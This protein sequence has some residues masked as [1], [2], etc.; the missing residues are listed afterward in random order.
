MCPYFVN[1]PRTFQPRKT[2]LFSGLNIW[3]QDIITTTYNNVET[4]QYV[5]K[6]QN[7]NRF[8]GGHSIS[9]KLHNPLYEGHIKRIYLCSVW[10]Y[11][12]DEYIALEWIKPEETALNLLDIIESNIIYGLKPHLNVQKKNTPPQI[13]FN[14]HIQNFCDTK[15]L[16]DEFVF[17]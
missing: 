12:N 13:G 8:K 5:G 11:F 3:G 10:F 16:N 9:L 6:T 14:I 17:N 1:Q 2:N 7:T 4:V 15:V